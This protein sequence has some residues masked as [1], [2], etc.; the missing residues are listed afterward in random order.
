MKFIKLKPISGISFYLNFD[1][2]IKLKRSEYQNY[3]LITIEGNLEYACLETPEEIQ[4]M[5]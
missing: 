2:V 1:K 4:D 5:L 3:T